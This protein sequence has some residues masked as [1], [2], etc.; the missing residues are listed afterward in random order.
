MGSEL[1]LKKEFDNIA[2]VHSGNDIVID[3]SSITQG[4]LKVTVITGDCV[5]LRSLTKEQAYGLEDVK[6]I[7]EPK[8]CNIGDVLEDGW[9]VAGK[10]PDSGLVFSIE[11]P[12]RAL[13]KGVSWY[14]GSMYASNIKELGNLNARLPSNDE[15]NIIFNNLVE[16]RHEKVTKLGSVCYWSSSER[17]NTHAWSQRFSDGGQGYNYKNDSFFIRC[18]RDEPTLSL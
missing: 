17:Y 3:L 14:Q 2:V 13:Q 18:V 6:V 4:D 5:Q 9:I 8:T 16:G 11:P 7:L 10:S 12:E 1:L 15:L